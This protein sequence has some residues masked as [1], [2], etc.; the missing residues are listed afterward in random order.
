M[1]NKSGR[2]QNKRYNYD[3]IPTVN[4]GDEQVSGRTV[5]SCRDS[6]RVRCKHDSYKFICQIRAGSFVG[7]EEGKFQ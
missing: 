5:D 7:L 4:G 2:I 6:I 3:I 1:V